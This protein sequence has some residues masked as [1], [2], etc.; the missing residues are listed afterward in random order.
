MPTSADIDRWIRT[1]GRLTGLP[2]L[3]P[4]AAGTCAFALDDG[5]RII[6][7][8]ADGGATLDLYAPMLEL[9]GQ[10]PEALFRDLLQRNDPARGTF[11]AAFA[12]DPRDDQVVLCV[13]R[14]T[15]DLDEASFMRLLMGFVDRARREWQA[16]QAPGDDAPD[17]AR[18]DA[19]P[20]DRLV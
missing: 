16:L 8:V 19:P 7:E 15:E 14:P 10:D 2:D 17:R 1:W 12:I 18:A 11:D 13:S 5:P 3:A 4:G 20:P 6:L 9:R